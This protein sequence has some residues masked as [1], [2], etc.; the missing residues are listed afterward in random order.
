MHVGMLSSYI[1][2][3]FTNDRLRRSLNVPI[4]ILLNV[5]TK[6]FWHA[7]KPSSQYFYVLLFQPRFVEVFCCGDK[8]FCM[9]VYVGL[10]ESL[11]IPLFS[12]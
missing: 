1:A 3:S 12:P 11:I 10:H 2:S 6:Y 9:Q 5:I 4:L 7:S 8:N